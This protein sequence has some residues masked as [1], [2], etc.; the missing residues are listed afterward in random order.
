MKTLKQIKELYDQGENV[1]QLLRSSYGIYHNT[2]EIIEISYDMQTGSY[3]E[4][5][6]DPAMQA[7]NLK[8]TQDV[9]KTILSLCDPV[10]IMEA[11][12][13]EATTLSGVCKNINK[14]EMT[15]Y[16]FDLC[17]SRVFYG[18]EWL[19]KQAVKNCQLFTG[20][21]FDIPIKDNAIDVVYTSHSIEPNGGHEERLIKELYRVTKKYLIL[22]EPGYE[23]ASEAAQKRM[24]KHGYCKNLFSTCKNLGLDVLRYELFPHASNPLNPTAIIVIKKNA[25]S[26]QPGSV[27]ACPKYKTPLEMIG[28]HY[29]SQ[30][31]LLVYPIIDGIP[32]LRIENGVL[33]SKYP[34][35]QKLS[36]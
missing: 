17:W 9:A 23:L 30:E 2:P 1:I 29:F 15:S 12:V 10:T 16:G 20:S 5:L 34:E 32:C 19:Q 13:G 27:F 35:T 18:R 7:F 11:G 4:G 36:S 8:Y 14:N 33:A 28:E 24:E 26:H 25:E 6:A 3:I 21:L 31:S 22:L